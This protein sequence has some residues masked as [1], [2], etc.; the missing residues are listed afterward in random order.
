M[1]RPSG[2]LHYQRD[3]WK[4]MC[5][6]SLTTKTSAPIRLTGDPG[7]V[8]CASCGASLRKIRYAGRLAD[9]R[10]PG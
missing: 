2:P 5:G 6:R 4:T 10:L 9:G 1:S 7:L 8:T 3:G